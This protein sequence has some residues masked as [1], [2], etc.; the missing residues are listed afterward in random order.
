MNLSK[1]FNTS[2]NTCHQYID[3][4]INSELVIIIVIIDVSIHLH[5]SF[6]KSSITSTVMHKQHVIEIVKIKI[7]TSSVTSSLYI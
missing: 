2:G 1:L 7:K 4:L 3:Q 6:K 5:I